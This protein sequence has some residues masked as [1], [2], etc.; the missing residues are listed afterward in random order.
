MLV[1]E[2]LHWADPSTRDFLTFLVRSARTEPLSP[3]RHVPLRRAAPP[4]PAA[5][6]AGR[7]RAHAGRRP[8]RAASASAAT[9]SIA[10]VASILERR[11]ARRSRRPPVRAQRGQPALHRGAA[12]GLR[13]RLPRAARDAA[14][15][16][17]RAR[18]AAAGDRA[19]GRAHDRGRAPDAPRAAGR[20]VATSTRPSCCAALREAVAHQV[21]VT[22]SGETYAFRH[23]LVGEAVYGD[24]LPGE[25]S[26]LHARLAE[27]VD[28]RPRA[29]GRRAG[30]GRA[31]GC[32][33]AT[34]TP[35][36][37]SRARSG[38]SVAAGLAAKRVFAF[39]EAQRHF[40]RALELWD[41][42]PDAEERAGCDRVDVL[43]H[44]AAAAANAGQAAP[45]ARAGAQGD[46][47]GGPAGGP[48]RAAFLL[49]AARALPALGRR[50][51]GGLRRLPAGDG[52]AARRAT[53]SSAPGCSST[54]RAGW[55]CAGASQ[56]APRAR[57]RRSR[58]PSG[59]R[60]RRRYGPGRSTRSGSRA[61]R[62]AR[63][64]RAS[65]C[66]AARA[67][68]RPS[69]PA[70][71]AGAWRSRTSATCSTSR[72][73]PRRR[74]PRSR[75]GWTALR[76][77]PERT[78]YDTFMELQGVTSMIRLG[79]LRELEAGLPAPQVRRLRR[80]HADLPR[81]LRARL[82][83]LVGDLGDGAAPARGAPPPVPGHARPAV[84]GA[85]ARAGGAAGA[86]RGPPG[87]R[88]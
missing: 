4:P 16:A 66:C 14:R 71:R 74:W 61:R 51:R 53:A 47:R 15:P 1:L 88:A 54:A 52:A 65:R 45:L 58:W 49:R 60:R 67:T 75:P 21:L 81:E 24:L 84:D 6:A 28:E 17:R 26:A 76:A 64:R 83:L 22:G 63:S 39:S 69:W 29:D 33:R 62:S 41:R 35:R 40:E 50:D 8:A 57:R 5:A 10:Q 36:T 68:S 13:R 11:G 3:G 46:R 25:R 44:A 34:G 18:R 43:R 37:T 78:S 73:A 9:R 2:D 70:S 79:R 82:A 80:H 27:A 19:G 32:S 7:A 20:A 86:A 31:R 38:R 77:N 56:A 48:V 59:S 12:G 87:G 42:V 55:C 23:A 72:A 85:A 30:R